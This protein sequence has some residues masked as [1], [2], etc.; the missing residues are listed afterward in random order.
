MTEKSPDVNVGIDM[1]IAA[2]AMLLSAVDIG[3]GGCMFRSIKREELSAI[4]GKEGYSPE[5]VIALGAPSEEVYLTE[6]R[7]GDIKYY[8]DELDR[9]A[10]PKLS[11]DEL[12]L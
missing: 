12:I 4:L 8:R 3:Y 6:A 11:L 5:L 2:E 10:V 9:H 1:G 7:N